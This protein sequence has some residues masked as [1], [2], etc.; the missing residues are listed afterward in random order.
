MELI[1][2]H[3][4]G[5]EEFRNVICD[6][7]ITSCGKDWRCIHLFQQIN[8]NIPLKIAFQFNEQYNPI[9]KDYLIQNG[10]SI[11]KIGENHVNDLIGYYENVFENNNFHDQRVLVD[12]SSMPQVS[13]SSMITYITCL[14]SE[15]KNITIYFAL[16]QGQYIKTNFFK[17]NSNL[18]LKNETL[19]SDIK[20]KALII[21]VNQDS[22][23]TKQVIDLIKPESVF[24]F[25][26]NQMVDDKYHRT[27]L[28]KHQK[29]CERMS[30]CQSIPYYV[31]KIEDTDRELTRICL[32]LRLNH[33]IIIVSNGPESFS[34]TAHLLN[35]RYPDIEIWDQ[36][37]QFS[38]LSPIDIPIIHKTI[39]TSEGDDY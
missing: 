27:I 31:D 20:K 18:S 10:F 19:L 12:Y 38:E 4:I 1:K 14:E 5:F 13:Y 35:A 28:E 25:L 33:K 11:L 9:I 34:L 30:S 22:E 23:L 3:A 17:K 36:E 26:P 39:F 8:Q 37:H 6:A 29:I 32:R 7:Y 2:S 15:I 16:T 21:G 24:L